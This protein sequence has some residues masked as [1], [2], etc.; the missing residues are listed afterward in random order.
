MLHVFHSAVGYLDTVS[1]EYFVQWLVGGK[2]LSSR[3]RNFLA[4]LVSTVVQNGGLNH[5][6]FLFMLRLRLPCCDW[7]SI[8]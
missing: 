2:C 1:I 4:T 6:M 8:G 5:V 3:S 7:S